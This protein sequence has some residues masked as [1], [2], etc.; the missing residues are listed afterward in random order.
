MKYM[1]NNNTDYLQIEHNHSIHQKGDKILTIFVKE[2]NP[3]VFMAE[4]F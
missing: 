1:P 3:V 4:T 2:V